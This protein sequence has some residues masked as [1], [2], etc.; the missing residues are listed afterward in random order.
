[1][2][3]YV[4]QITAFTEHKIILRQMPSNAR[5]ESR[6]SYDSQSVGTKRKTDCW[7]ELGKG[8][9]NSRKRCDYS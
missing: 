6:R 8:Q 2:K 5:D 7:R 3:I 4:F 9:P 1:L